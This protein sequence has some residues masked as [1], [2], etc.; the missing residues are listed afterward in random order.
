MYFGAGVPKLSHAAKNLQQAWDSSED[1][2]RDQVRN[3]IEKRHIAPALDTTAKT[4]RAM[5]QLAD[6][7]ARIYR[8]LT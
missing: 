2:W 1:G 8:D 6:M 7:F 4:L 3:D 5:D